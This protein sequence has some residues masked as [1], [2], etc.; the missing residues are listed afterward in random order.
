[1]AACQAPTD[2][3]ALY[4]PIAEAELSAFNTGNFS[5]LDKYN[6]PDLERHFGIHEYKG[7]AAA[8][9]HSKALHDAYD[10]MHQ[11]LDD[12]VCSENKVVARCT[13]TGKLKGTNI[14]WKVPSMTWYELKD[15]KIVRSWTTVDGTD[16]LQRIGFKLIPPTAAVPTPTK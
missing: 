7:L 9:E 14:A 16:E 11:T 5:L 6:A 3:T 15:N 4:K 12:L 8:K 10:D 1:M 13:T 2:Y